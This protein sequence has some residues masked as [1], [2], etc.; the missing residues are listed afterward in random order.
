MTI[1]MDPRNEVLVR[2]RRRS[3]ET[4]LCREDANYESRR[5]ISPRAHPLPL[6]TMQ[7]MSIQN[8]VRNPQKSCEQ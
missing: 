5:A 8:S 3:W 6:W 1:L 2:R 7:V 4:D